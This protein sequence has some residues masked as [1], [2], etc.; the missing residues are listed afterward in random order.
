MMNQRDSFYER[1]ISKSQFFDGKASS[2]EENLTETRSND[3]NVWFDS[4]D[5]WKIGKT[6]HIW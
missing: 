4:C 3:T 1:S 5:D 6:H 2:L